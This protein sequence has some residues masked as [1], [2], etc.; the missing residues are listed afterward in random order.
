MDRCKVI[1]KYCPKCGWLLRA[2]WMAQELLNTFG[3]E[4]SEL[5]LVPSETGVFEVEVESELVWSR[6]R[7]NGFPQIKEL[8]KR[9]RD[10]L[11]PDRDLGHIDR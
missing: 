9:V 8:K 1:I 7:D 10:I 6:T 4:I 5:S 11:S 3:N 2:S